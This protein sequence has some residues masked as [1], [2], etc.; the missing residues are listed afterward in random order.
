MPEAFSSIA[1]M[2]V[3]IDSSTDKL[4]AGLT[5]AQN[6]VK[7]FADEGNNNLSLLD[8]ALGKTGDGAGNLGGMLKGLFDGLVGQGT[9][10]SVEAI[11]TKITGLLGKLNEFTAFL[12]LTASAVNPVGN[13][14]ASQT[15]TTKE[16]DDVQ[17][18]ASDLQD[19]L[20]GSLYVAWDETKEKALGAA[21][22]LLGFENAA[23][24]SAT[25]TGIVAN[26]FRGLKDALDA[27][28]YGF[29]NTFI[30][31]KYQSL[32]TLEES[33]TRAKESLAALQDQLA[34]LQSMNVAVGGG[35]RSILDRQTQR[36]NRKDANADLRAQSVGRRG[37]DL[38]RWQG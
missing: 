14:I 1:N 16:W 24:L 32:G 25:S 19:V 23:D 9:A 36:R 33:V 37:E 8:R 11:A 17:K 6:L 10:E 29:E 31:E 13:F 5:A 12:Q 4:E 27:L 30:P 18:S 26:A 20:T 35:G 34:A 7:R 15:G 28:K 21:S 22:G 38:S 3:V 2:R